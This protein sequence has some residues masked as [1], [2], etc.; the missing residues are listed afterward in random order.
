MSN[1]NVEADRDTLIHIPH[2]S[3]WPL[4]QPCKPTTQ[5]P[6]IPFEQDHAGPWSAEDTKFSAFYGSVESKS[7]QHATVGKMEQAISLCVASLLLPHPPR[8]CC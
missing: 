7:Y 1:T 2:P 5:Y 6:T 8:Q 4:P 3:D